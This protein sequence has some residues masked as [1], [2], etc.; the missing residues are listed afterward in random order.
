MARAKHKLTQK[1]V[2]KLSKVDGRYSDGDGLYLRTA[3]T[4]AK[5]TLLA[6]VQG[7]KRE[8][9]LGAFPEVD[10]A[11][12]RANAEEKKRQI[13]SGDVEVK[14]RAKPKTFGEFALAY[15][16][17]QADGWRNDKHES[18]WRMTLSIQQDEEGRWI[19]SGYCTSIRDLPLAAIG[20]DEV[21]SILRPIWLEKAETAAR[22]RARL[23]TVLGAAIAAKLRPAPN[24]ATLKGNLEFF[25]PRRT[26]LQRGHHAAADIDRVPVIYKRLRDSASSSPLGLCFLILTAA[27][28]GEVIGATWDEIDLERALW[29]IPAARM[30][31]GREHTVPLSAAAVEILKAMN[32]KAEGLVF[33]SPKGKAL[34]QM[35]L[36]MALRRAMEEGEG[37]STVHGFRSSF[38]DWAG[39]R[40]NF[41]R[42]D[43]EASL[44]HIVRDATERAYRRAT[45][46]DK[47][48][49]IMD[50]WAQ[51][52]ENRS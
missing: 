2:A 33:P 14:V 30:K 36:T 41:Q 9:G 31:A 26:K 17:G 47:R 15:V 1:I 46:L 39:D 29:M 37:H 52:V 5:W 16:N 10:L 13:A 49:V 32:P 7:R 20:Q 8:Y 45:A 38:R 24:P 19:D 40:T 3:G 43:I 42:D 6:T 48:R 28:T 18:Q 25:L 4:S 35:A 50:E 21:L 34:S 51:F 11:T 44:A 27:R 12:A 23:E 22:T